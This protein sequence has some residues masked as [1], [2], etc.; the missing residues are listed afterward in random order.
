MNGCGQT[1]DD[2]SLALRCWSWILGCISSQFLT[3][4]GRLDEWIWRWSAAW[5]SRSCLTVCSSCITLAALFCP[6]ACNQDAG[7][8]GKYVDVL[9][10]DAD[11]KIW[12]QFKWCCF[13]WKHVIVCESIRQSKVRCFL[14]IFHQSES[15]S[16]KSSE[17][18]KIRF[19]MH[20]RCS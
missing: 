18:I 1:G 3:L 5:R 6:Q 2:P 10:S 19:A 17:C 20:L 9:Y 11:A 4:R 7:R 13:D 16:K 14:H 15:S 12:F 8:W